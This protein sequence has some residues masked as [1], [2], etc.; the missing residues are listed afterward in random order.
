MTPHQM[1][2]QDIWG[3]AHSHYAL[4][5]P[6][7]GTVYNEGIKLLGDGKISAVP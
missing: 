4:P 6:S 7:S 3:Q 1:P 5:G 2:M